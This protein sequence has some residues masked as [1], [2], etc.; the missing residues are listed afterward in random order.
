MKEERGIEKN[1]VICYNNRITNTP[2]KHPTSMPVS[3]HYLRW[4]GALSILAIAGISLLHTRNDI[5]ASLA[6]L[7]SSALG[8]IIGII[9]I[10]LFCEYLDSTLG[11]GYGTIMTPLLLFAGYEPV[12]IVPSILLSELLTGITASVGHQLSGNVNMRP[13]TKGFKIAM[14]LGVCSLVGTTVGSALALR[15]PKDVMVLIIGSIITLMGLAVIIQQFRRSLRFSWT[16][17]TIIGIIASFNKG[18]SGGGYGPLVTGGQVVAGVDAKSAIAISSFAESL[19]CLVGVI[20]FI[21]GGAAIDWHLM[22]GIGIGSLLSVPLSVLTVKRMQARMM[23]TII[24]TCTMLMGLL[25][26]FNIAS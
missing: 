26:L 10:S 7:D 19:T 9:V 2:M 3:H 8:F 6:H 17:V 11:M 22:I 25:M 20:I 15:L 18:I 14:I 21:A 5:A 23:T 16:K 4:A 1:P 13:G 24:G 12:A